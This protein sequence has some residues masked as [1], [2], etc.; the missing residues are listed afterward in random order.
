MNVE[1]KYRIL[2]A[3]DHTLFRQGMKALLSLEEVLYWSD[4]VENSISKT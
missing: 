4:I 3:E 1:K 2:L